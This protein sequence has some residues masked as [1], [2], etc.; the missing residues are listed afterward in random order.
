MHYIQNAC[1][2]YDLLCKQT[3]QTIYQIWEADIVWISVKYSNPEN[4]LKPQIR[5][6]DNFIWVSACFR[7]PCTTSWKYFT[8]R[9]VYDS[10]LKYFKVRDASVKWCQVLLLLVKLYFG[11]NEVLFTSCVSFLITMKILNNISPRHCLGNTDSSPLFLLALCFFFNGGRSDFRHI[12]KDLKVVNIELNKLLQFD[13]HCWSQ[14]NILTGE[15]AWILI[16][17]YKYCTSYWCRAAQNTGLLIYTEKMRWFFPLIFR[18]FSKQFKFSFAAA[19][20]PFKIIMLHN[21]YF[22]N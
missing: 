22:S 14:K 16:D 10:F 21:V 11:I 17:V 8:D 19:R 5:N 6:N 18:L 9:M 15:R 3:P 7:I 13:T 1:L 4:V 12:G 20:I 2:N